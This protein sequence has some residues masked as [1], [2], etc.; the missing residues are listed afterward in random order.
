[1][2]ER[3]L[4]VGC[5]KMGRALLDGWL[6]ADMVA[7]VDVVEPGTAPVPDDPRVRHYLSADELD[8]KPDVVVLAVKPQAMD[9]VIDQYHHFARPDCVFLSIAA[10]KTLSYLQRH[11]GQHT[12]IVRAMPNTPAAVGKGISVLVA[13]ADA[14]QKETCQ[15]LL[16]VV[17]LTEWVEDEGLIDIVTA[18]SGGGPAYVFL[19]IEALTEAGAKAGLPTD[20]AMH[21][22]RQTVI[23]SGALAELSDEPAA[24]LRRNVTSPQGTTEAALKILMA[25]NGIQPIF[26]RAIE[27]AAERSR[28]LDA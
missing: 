22:A 2:I 7:H 21:L 17:G 6:G 3:V 12:H 14:K 5:G 20:L 28:E 19:L 1:M 18:L 16:E 9:A 15:H 25:E 26:D 23:G 11:L 10:G 27:A 4:L 13:D 8:A 24:Q